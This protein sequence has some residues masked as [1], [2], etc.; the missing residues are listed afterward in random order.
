MH[1]RSFRPPSLFDTIEEETG[2]RFPHSQLPGWSNP[3]ALDREDTLKKA[4]KLLRQGRLDAAI[5]EYLRVVE[6]PR[7]WNTANALG[8]L[9]ARG[10]QTDKAAAQYARIA[11]HLMRRG[12]L[13]ESRRALQE[14]PQGQSGRRGDATAAGRD[15]GEAGAAADAKNYFNA[16]ATKRRGRGDRAGTAEI[17]IRLGS[18]DPADIDARMAAARPSPRWATRTRGGSI[19]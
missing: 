1:R 3:L 18:L 2:P 6:D 10:G 16:V 17:V 13:S 11:D 14:A 7:D 4:E 15:L 9:Y 12:L 8:D 19:P 5:A